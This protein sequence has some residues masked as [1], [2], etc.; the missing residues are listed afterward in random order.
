MPHRCAPFSP[1]CCIPVLPQ[2]SKAKGKQRVSVDGG[3]HIRKIIG[4]LR[5]KRKRK[6]SP[7]PSIY[8]D[9][10]HIVE[11]VPFGS[12][13]IPWPPKPF[14]PL[15]FEPEP[16]EGKG[17]MIGPRSE[18]P[19]YATFFGGS[20]VGKRFGCRGYPAF[21]NYRF[22]FP[23]TDQ[24]KYTTLFK[25]IKSVWGTPEE[26]RKAEEEQVFN[27]KSLKLDDAG[28]NGWLDFFS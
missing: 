9:D 28:Y 22:I 4:K 6:S 15:T 10:G 21:H 25:G 14:S 18:F 3:A 17:S 16:L 1:P 13:G 27:K 11:E 5:A 7:K 20:P 26:R 19:G 8:P 12:G 24:K 2:A 23:S